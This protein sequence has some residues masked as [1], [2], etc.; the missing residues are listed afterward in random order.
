[1]YTPLVL[2]MLSLILQAGLVHYANNVAGAAAREGARV[3][4]S[5]T[6]TEPAARTAAEAYAQK[7]GSGVLLGVQAEPDRNLATGF[8]E[9]EV[10]GRAI[11]VLPGFP[12]N[13]SKTSRGPIER[14]IPDN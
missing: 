4:R 1:M 2:L 11:A 8:A 7:V 13:V 9:V 6:G 10:T 12:V 14:F 5:E 3:A